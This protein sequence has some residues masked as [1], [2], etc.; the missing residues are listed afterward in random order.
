MML[1]TG[2]PC[3]PPLRALSRFPL[4]IARQFVIVGEPRDVVRRPYVQCRPEFWVI[5]QRCYAQEDM[6]L[7]WALV[8]HSMPHREPKRG[9]FPGEDSYKRRISSPAIQRKC[10]RRTP[11]VAAYVL[12]WAFRH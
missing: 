6:Q 7:G 1:G 11:A 4:G 2:R 8:H 5:I 10:S 9:S 12:A 3:P